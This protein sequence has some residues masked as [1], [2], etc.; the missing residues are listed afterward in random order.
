MALPKNFWTPKEK[1]AIEHVMRGTSA[2]IF[3]NASSYI[4]GQTESFNMGD[5]LGSTGSIKSSFNHHLVGVENTA[6]SFNPP[7]SLKSFS[8]SSFILSCSFLP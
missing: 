8:N 1:R 4:S 2:H 5:T 7:S 3:Y 6:K